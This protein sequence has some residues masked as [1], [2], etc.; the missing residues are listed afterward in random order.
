MNCEFDFYCT[1]REGVNEHY[2][3]TRL[4][5]ATIKDISL[6]SADAM[7]NPGGQPTKNISFT[8]NSM[9]WEHC[10]AGSIAYILWNARVSD[11]IRRI[12]CRGL[13]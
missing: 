3:K 9:T 10:L 12:I 8:Y 1:N 5:K 6:S 7:N 2:E 11:F 4:T 13:Q